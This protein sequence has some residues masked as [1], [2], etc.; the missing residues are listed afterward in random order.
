MNFSLPGA[1]NGMMVTA[2]ISASIATGPVC[3]WLDEPHI[4]ATTTGNREAYSPYTTGKP[5]S[6]A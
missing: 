6:W 2:E 3:S 4:D 1:A 5:A